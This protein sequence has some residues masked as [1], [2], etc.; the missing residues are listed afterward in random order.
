MNRG[1]VLTALKLLIAAGLI[2]WV[3]DTAGWDNIRDAL[4]HI[5]RTGWI[6]GLSAIILANL[7]AMLRW[8]LLMRSAGLRSTPWLAIRLGFIG[9]FS[10]K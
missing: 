1:H 9:V 4:A 3:I 2:Y 6:M 5:D 7:L 8:H 10:N